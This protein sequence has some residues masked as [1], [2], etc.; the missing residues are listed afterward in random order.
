MA[1]KPK[2][3]S[4]QPAPVSV[5]APTDPRPIKYRL[6]DLETMPAELVAQ[7]K[8]GF[9]EHLRRTA[10]KT[11]AAEQ[12]GVTLFVIER[13]LTD[14]LRFQEDA[15]HATQARVDELEL[16]CEA[17]TNRSGGDVTAR[18][19]TIKGFRPEKYQ[20]RI[21]Q[22]TFQHALYEPEFVFEVPDG[23]AKVPADPDTQT[24]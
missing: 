23:K 21:V 18:I 9:L 20:E 17:S 14:D 5:Q 24:H 4:Q 1:G 2:R 15:E 16:D 12:V 11:L 6:G 3:R 13:W 10:R 22:Q 8:C 7:L 19:F